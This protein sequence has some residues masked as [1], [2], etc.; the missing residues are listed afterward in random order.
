MEEEKGGERRRGGEKRVCA[1]E[2][3]CEHYLQEFPILGSADGAGVPIAKLEDALLEA[4]LIE[5]RMA[6]AVTIPL[7]AGGSSIPRYR[8]VPKHLHTQYVRKT[9]ERT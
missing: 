9:R 1:S 6:L 7:F 5:I 4:A 8:W 3:V 2:G